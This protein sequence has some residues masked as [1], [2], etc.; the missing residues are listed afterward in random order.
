V[1]AFLI[2]LAVGCGHKGQE[3]KEVSSPDGG[4]RAL[5]PGT[6][7]DESRT[8]GALTIKAQTVEVKDGAFLASYT[9]LP[10]GTPFNYDAGIQGMATK[11]QGRVLS[12]TDVSV[13]GKPGKA[14]E[15]EITQP[16]GFAAGRMAVV[17]G[18]LYQ[19]LVIGANRRATDPDVQKFFDSFELTRGQPTPPAPPPA[20]APSQK[21]QPDDQTGQAPFPAD[22]KLLQPDTK[23]YLSDMQEFGVKAGPWPFGKNGDVGNPDHATI[24][25]NGKKSP[26]G[27]GLHV[28]T[29]FS[30]VRYQP[31][32]Q[33]RRFHA[34]VALDDTNAG[35]RSGVVFEVLGDGKSLWTSKLIETKGQTEDCD[36]DVSGV[37]QLELRVTL[38]GSGFGGHSVWVDPY[39]EK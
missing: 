23:V 14:F 34:T 19:L 7:K 28:G 1:V 33:A 10:R 38:K 2:A 8:Q 31:G 25:V 24:T 18:R 30:S 35:K 16:K 20:A 26:K 12:T 13:G 3:W 37:N 36:V 6:P 17:D 29:P 39:L 5:M 22:P 9:D 21:S 15:L 32:K 11:H 27:L 4:Y